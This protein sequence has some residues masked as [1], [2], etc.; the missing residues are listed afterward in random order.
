MQ[1]GCYF[2]MKGR[3]IL[4][5]LEEIIEA[6]LRSP[7]ARTNSEPEIVPERFEV[8][9]Q[10]YNRFAKLSGKVPNIRVRGGFNAGSVSIEIPSMQLNEREVLELREILQNCNTFEVVP[11][12]NG[13]VGIGVTVK[14]VVK[15]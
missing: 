9:T 4:F 11:L 5:S 2:K 10:V 6:V 12:A 15:I 8:L 1:S 14:G 7:D 13:E 3:G